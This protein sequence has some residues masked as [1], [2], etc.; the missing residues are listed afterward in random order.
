MEPIDI[1]PTI[2]AQSYLGVKADDACHWFAQCDNTATTKT[3]HPTLGEVPT[4]ARCDERVKQL[5]A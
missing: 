5:R 3:S 2:V 1:P 4:C